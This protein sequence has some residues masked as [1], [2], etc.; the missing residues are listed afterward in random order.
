MSACP[1]CCQTYDSRFALCPGCL[2]GPNSLEPSNIAS[3]ELY[4]ELGRGGMGVVYRANHISLGREVAVKV[5]AADIAEYQDFQRRLEREA[6]ILALLD[7]ENVVRVFD[8]GKDEGQ[9]FLAMELVKGEP[10]SKIL[11]GL[12]TGSLPIDRAL[13]IA[14]RVAAALTHAHERGVIH[15]DIKPSNIFITEEGSVKVGDFGIARLVGGTADLAVTQTNVAVGSP[16]YMSPEALSG[17]SPAPSMDVYSLGVLLYEM[18]AGHLPVGAFPSLDDPVDVVVRKALA[19]DADK[20]YA[21]MEAMG[22]ALVIAANREEKKQRKTRWPAARLLVAGALLTASVGIWGYTRSSE[23]IAQENVFQQGLN[24]YQGVSDHWFSRRSNEHF[25]TSR[26]LRTS[27]WDEAN[28][29]AVLQFRELF[30]SMKWQVSSSA[31]IVQATLVLVVPT[32]L[33]YSDGEFNS[34]HKLLVNWHGQGGWASTAWAGG[35][36]SGIDRDDIEASQNSYDNSSRYVHET[37]SGSLIPSGTTLEFDV[38]EIVRDWSHG[39]PNY[40]F[41]LQSGGTMNG[42]GLFMASSRWPKRSA[43]PALRIRYESGETNP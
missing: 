28:Q 31:T 34:V 42:N 27:H 24:G 3:L 8:A 23:N 4:E 39:E 37:L 16:A 43:R 32:E 9:L 35:A 30:G 1:R 10:L 36:T 29:Q 19:T 5:M 13:I 20:R 33:E 25:H 18:V 15:R 6:R 22:N 11:S 26:Y 7:H 40:G 38:T 41:L 17:N 2:L 14:I 12:P 21:S